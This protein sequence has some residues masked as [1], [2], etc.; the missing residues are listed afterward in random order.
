M[1][2]TSIGH[3]ARSKIRNRGFFADCDFYWEERMHRLFFLAI[4]GATAGWTVAAA[5]DSN[6]HG[7]YAFTGM[8][9]CIQDSASLGFN[10]NLTPKGPASFFTFSVEGTR[11]F[12]ADGTGMV[13]GRSVSIVSPPDASGN[14]DDFSFKFTYTV[15]PGGQL[16]TS[17]VPGSFSGT[18][19][20]GPRAGQTYVD[21]VPMQS[22]FI[23]E[24]AQTIVLHEQVPTV[25][26][27][28]FSNGD[29]FLRICNRSRVL[30]R[31]HNEE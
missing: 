16:S 19:L 24:G 23:G 7:T 18:A 1:R 28:S 29:M 2:K 17:L 3:F 22:G 26:S 12:H 8:S 25:E 20:T 30:I 27:V 4:A 6:L 5:A 10:P 13:S 11:T 15:D 21:D 9:S 31:L 14:S